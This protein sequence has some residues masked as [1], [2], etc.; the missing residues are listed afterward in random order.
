MRRPALALAS[1]TMLSLAAFV[2]GASALPSQEPPLRIAAQDIKWKR[3][4]KTSPDPAFPEYTRLECAKIKAPLDWKKPNGKKITLAISRLKARKKPQGVI[5]TNPGGPGGAGR[6]LPLSL[7]SAGRDR[8]LDTMDVIGVDVRGTGGGTKARC[9]TDPPVPT[10]TRDLSA[11]NAKAMLT[12]S[13]R[14]ADSCRNGGGPL[15]AEYVTT[16]QTVHDLEWIR[17]NLETSDGKK[18]KKIHWIGYS[19]GTWLGAHYAKRWPKSTGRFVLDS[20][21]DYTG[22]WQ[23]WTDSQPK[24]FWDRFRQFARWAAGNNGQFGLGASEKAVLNTYEEIRAVIA[25]EG[26]V[27]LTYDDGSTQDLYPIDFDQ[28]IWQSL[29]SK[30]SFIETAGLMSALTALTDG[31]QARARTLPKALNA[32]PAA[33]IY[34][35]GAV[36]YDVTCGD[37][38]YSRTPKQQSSAAA[39]LGK[40][41]PLIGYDLALNPC[42]YWKQA[43]GRLKLARPAGNDL[44]GMLLV[45]S[46]YDPATP[47]GPALKVHKRY[48]NSR[49]VTVRNEGDHAL[50]AGDNPCVDTIVEQWLV[51]GVLPKADRTCQGTPIPDPAVAA[52]TAGDGPVNPVLLA[53]ELAERLPG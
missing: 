2:P 53:R 47:Y 6:T 9:K 15:P 31:G 20:A 14:M 39:K 42:P 19:N 8:V 32:R 50:Y 21:V 51:D 24:G 12:W 36:F 27:K 37:M 25:K 44:P 48:A 30:Y 52:R 28:I 18:V 16:A 40:K 38:K 41:Y 35:E 43:S 29:Y 3:C 26:Y 13:K 4:F 46:V 17:R 10:N 11:G 49:M 23:K 5:F 22:T 7:I 1:V 33:A 45:Q 34:G